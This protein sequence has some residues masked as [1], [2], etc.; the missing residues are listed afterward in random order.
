M[1][2]SKLIA[3]GSDDP[4]YFTQKWSINIETLKACVWY[5]TVL[6]L[7]SYKSCQISQ[8]YALALQ[9]SYGWLPFSSKRRFV[10]SFRRGEDWT[11]WYA[12]A[13]GNGRWRCGKI[14]KIPLDKKNIA[15][16]FLGFSFIVFGLSLTVKVLTL[17]WEPYLRNKFVGI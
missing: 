12:R 17:R 7:F 15:T 16:F 3:F 5:P 2:L 1:F 10:S 14:F 4:S 9:E 13:I 8:F 11:R 6:W